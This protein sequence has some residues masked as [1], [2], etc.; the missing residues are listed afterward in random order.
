MNELAKYNAIRRREVEA[1]RDE[2]VAAHRARTV[3]R[4]ADYPLPGLKQRIADALS[5][6][7]GKGRLEPQFEVI[8]RGAFGGD[9]SVK[10]PQ[11]LADGG[12]KAFVQTH[13]PWIVETLQQPAFGDAIAAGKRSWKRR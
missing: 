3:P 10:F 7:W 11:L 1:F 9:L 13:L 8:D 12:P 5:A 2:R 4:L 6:R